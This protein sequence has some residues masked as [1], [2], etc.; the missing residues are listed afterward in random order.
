VSI[1]RSNG[2]EM[3]KK[4]AAILVLMDVSNQYFRANFTSLVLLRCA[5]S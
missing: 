3:R 1:P 5:Y 4:Y 2:L